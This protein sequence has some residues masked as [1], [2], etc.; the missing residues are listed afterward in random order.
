M[1][2]GIAMVLM[3]IVI[4]LYTVIIMYLTAIRVREEQ[5]RIQQW[6]LKRARFAEQESNKS[7]TS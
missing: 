7:K 4:V 6:K 2:D 5:R 1:I 3:M